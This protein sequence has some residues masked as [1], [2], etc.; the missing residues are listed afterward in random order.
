[1]GR[2]LTG[3]HMASTFDVQNDRETPFQCRNKAQ[4]HKR[5]KKHRSHRGNP[6]ILLAHYTSRTLPKK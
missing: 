2:V 3:K 6:T 1:V 5:L 4:W